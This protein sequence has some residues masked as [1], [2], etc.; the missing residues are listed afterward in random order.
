MHREF[1]PTCS[2]IVASP[3][4]IA[5]GAVHGEKVFLIM[6]LLQGAFQR[7]AASNKGNSKGNRSARPLNAAPC[8]LQGESCWTLLLK[9]ARTQ[10][11]MHEQS[12]ARSRAG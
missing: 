3:F 1:A 10:R 9:R 2:A 8:L 4:F 7:E 5:E 6:E 11:A 12:S